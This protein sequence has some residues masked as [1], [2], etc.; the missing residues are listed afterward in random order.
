MLE[1]LKGEVL[2]VVKDMEIRIYREL[3]GVVVVI[4]FFS[5]LFLFKREKGKVG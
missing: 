3:L 1:L 2:E 5:E 4:C